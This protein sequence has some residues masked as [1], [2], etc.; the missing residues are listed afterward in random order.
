MHPHQEW[1]DFAAQQDDLAKFF[2]FYLKEEQNDW[3]L[4]PRIRLSLLRFNG[5]PII[6]RALEV[7]P[8]P[9]SRQ[10]KFFLDNKTRTATASKPPRVSQIAYKSD[11]DEIHFDLIFDRYT[12]LVG[13]CTVRLH[14]QCFSHD[15]LDIFVICR[16]LDIKGRALHHVNFPTEKSAEQL[17][18]TNVVQ[19]NGPTGRLRASHRAIEN[20][21]TQAP[22]EIFHPHN[23]EEKIKPGRIVAVD[24]GTWPMGI[25]YE[26]G[27][28]LRLSVSGR[29]MCFP[30][31]ENCEYSRHF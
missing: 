21:S 28:G 20:S 11:G 26:A 30:E 4:T 24:I 31:M 5:P 1:Y 27:E 3:K 12:E 10:M 8:P 25:V 29:D 7:Y 15:D 19:Y 17:P 16:K 18:Q 2:G 23:N 13:Y 9:Q 14:V 6:N 22:G